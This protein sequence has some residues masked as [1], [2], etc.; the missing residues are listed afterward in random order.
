MLESDTVLSGDWKSFGC[1]TGTASRTVSLLRHSQVLESLA[2]HHDV[3]IV[4]KLQMNTRLSC[5]F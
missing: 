4:A 5:L 2:C 3:D 1:P